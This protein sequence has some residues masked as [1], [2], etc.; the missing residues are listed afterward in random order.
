MKNLSFRLSKVASY[1]SKGSF[2]A[3]VGS[4]HGALPI[5]LTNEGISPFVQAIEN[6]KGPFLR[7]S[8]AV[9]EEALYPER[10][11]LSLSSG[12]AALDP[13]ADT[14]VIAGMGGRLISS[15]LEEHPEK[16]DRIKTLILDAHSEWDVLLLT[17]AKLGYKVEEESFFYEDNIW[18]SVWK[19]A[20]TDEDIFYSQ[21]ELL[22]GP[23]ECHR[24]NSDWKRFALEKKAQYERLLKND[25]PEKRKTEIGKELKILEDVMNED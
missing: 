5:Y 16:L 12:L 25:I 24:H 23:L 17:C 1:V 19:L 4:D 14:V 18:Y 22:F 10:I 15:I 8:K 21:A 3:D 6:K 13:K 7:L 2:V 11:S 20:K 9:E